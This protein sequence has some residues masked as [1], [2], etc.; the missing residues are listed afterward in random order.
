MAYF[1]RSMPWSSFSCRMR[2]RLT[3]VAAITPVRAQVSVNQRVSPVLVRASRHCTHCCPPLRLYA[4]I[5]DGARKKSATI[6]PIR[7]QSSALNMLAH[8]IFPHNLISSNKKYFT[9]QWPYLDEYESHA[10][11]LTIEATSSIKLAKHGPNEAEIN[12]D[13]DE[14]QQPHRSHLCAN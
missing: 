6:I 10:L 7:P 2:E 11:D 4:A 1:K 3:A 12:R 14:Q 5:N 13:H 9:A 8:M